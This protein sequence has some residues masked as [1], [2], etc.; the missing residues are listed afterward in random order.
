MRDH[1][2]AAQTASLFARLV[3]VVTSKFGTVHLGQRKYIITLLRAPLHPALRI[4]VQKLEPRHA[5]PLSGKIATQHLLQ[6]LAVKVHPV[7]DTVAAKDIKILLAVDRDA[8]AAAV[9]D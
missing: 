2:H 6:M 1:A 4:D 7:E 5:L 3:A 9:H 8:P